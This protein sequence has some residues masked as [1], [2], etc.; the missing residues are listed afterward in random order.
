M[1]SLVFAPRSVA[2]CRGPGLTGAHNNRPYTDYM[3]F[4]FKFHSMKLLKWQH[5]YR[6]AIILYSSD[7]IP[8]LPR[9]ACCFFGLYWP[10]ETFKVFNW[11]KT[12]NTARRVIVN[13]IKT[14]TVCTCTEEGTLCSKYRANRQGPVGPDAPVALRVV[15]RFRSRSCR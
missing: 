13:S 2:F 4:F 12:V 14:H 6:R 10:K 11:F 9:Y 5:T 3:K 8:V 15:A 7:R 1:S